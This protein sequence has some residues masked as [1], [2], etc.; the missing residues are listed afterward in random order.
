MF[1]NLKDLHARIMDDGGGFLDNVPIYTEP[2][3]IFRSTKYATI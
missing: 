1:A 2:T 3:L